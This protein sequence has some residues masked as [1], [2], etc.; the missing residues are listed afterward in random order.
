MSRDPIPEI[1][2]A[3]AMF[4]VVNT[5]YCY[6]D[7]KEDTRMDLTAVMILKNTFAAPTP[8]IDDVQ[9]LTG[10]GNAKLRPPD[11]Q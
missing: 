8:R 4:K 11:R 6:R 5:S 9:T 10:T 7:E 2:V 1:K 3:M